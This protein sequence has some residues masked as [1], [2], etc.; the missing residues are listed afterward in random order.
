MTFK[1]NI[2]KGLE[3]HVFHCCSNNY[4]FGLDY[5]YFAICNDSDL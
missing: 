4:D 2:V 1:M 3:N 5:Q